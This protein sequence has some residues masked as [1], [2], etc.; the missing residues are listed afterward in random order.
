[1]AKKVLT[2]IKLQAPGG[3]ASSHARTVL[4]TGRDHDG[5][6]VTV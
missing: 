2:Q 5:A 3:T 4:T 6:P 1:M